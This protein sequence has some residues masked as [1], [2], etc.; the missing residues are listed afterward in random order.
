MGLLK[1][2]DMYTIGTEVI[3]EWGSSFFSI[4]LPNQFS[5]QTDEILGGRTIESMKILAWRHS[6]RG[7]KPLRD[8]KE[9]WMEKGP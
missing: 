2:D 9:E 3:N 8:Q 1:G 7:K 6:V 5:M 4:L